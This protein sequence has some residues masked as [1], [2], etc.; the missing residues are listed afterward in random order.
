MDNPLEVNL[1]Y[2]LGYL[3]AID[4]YYIYKRD[5]ELAFYLLKNLKFIK[6]ENDIA[7][8]LRRNHITFMDD[9]YE[10]LKKYIKEIER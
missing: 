2:S 10:N 4:L 7:S 8:M 6:Q 9:G 3:V 1:K 5:P